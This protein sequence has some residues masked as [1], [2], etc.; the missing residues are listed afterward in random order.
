MLTFKCLDCN[1]NS[2]KKFDG[3]LTKN[4]IT[5]IGSVMEILLNFVTCCGKVFMHMTT[6]IDGKSSIKHPF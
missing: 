2:E 1:K 5:H 3:D 4:L 6:R